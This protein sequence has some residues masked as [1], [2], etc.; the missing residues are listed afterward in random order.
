MLAVAPAPAVATS[1]YPGVLENDDAPAVSGDVE[2]GGSAVASPGE[3]SGQ[4]PID[5]AYQWEECSTACAPIP[6]ATAPAYTPAD[7]D[8]GSRLAVVVTATNASASYTVSSGPS[9]AVAPAAEEVQAALVGQLMPHGPTLAVAI[10]VQTKR[11]YPLVFDAPVSGQVTVDWY[12]G[13]HPGLALPAHGLTMIAT[14]STRVR[15]TGPTAIQLKATARGHLLIKRKRSLDLTAVATITPI[16]S[17]PVSALTIF[18]L[19]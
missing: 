6:G 9:Q 15:Q 18:T 7:G 5:Y 11:G 13:R 16:Q 3:W 14:G 2:V 4:G 17:Q 8:Q 12:Q 1:G 10:G 19:R